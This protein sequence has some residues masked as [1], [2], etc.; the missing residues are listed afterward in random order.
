[1]RFKQ[2]RQ[3][4]REMRIP[5]GLLRQRLTVNSAGEQKILSLARHS[6]TARMQ[7]NASDQSR[8]T[9]IQKCRLLPKAALLERRSRQSVVRQLSIQQLPL[10][11]L[12]PVIASSTIIHCLAFL[13][14]RLAEEQTACL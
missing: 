7:G 10:V 9:A 3:S 12:L 14:I 6:K 8:K 13:Q 5:R 2:D 1:M 11:H 4:L